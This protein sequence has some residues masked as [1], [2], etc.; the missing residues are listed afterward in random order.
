MRTALYPGTF[1][2][3]TN[4]HISLIRRG[5]QVFDRIIVAVADRTPKTP[6]FSQE[7]RVELMRRA[8]ADLKN[9]EVVPFTGLTVE[10]AVERG[11]S[12]ILRG[13]RAISDFEM[14]FQLALM[15]R[16]LNNAIETVFL[17]TDYRWLFISSTIVKNAVREGGTARGLV[18]DFVQRELEKAF[19]LRPAVE[20]GH[21]PLTWSGKNP[22]TGIK[23]RTAVYP[24]TFD[25]ITNGHLSVIRRALTT[26]DK[27]IVAVAENAGKKPLFSLAER[28]RF[29]EES[30]SDQAG[31]VEVAPYSN[32]TVDFAREHGA[33]AIVRGLR[34]TGDFEY[35]F[36]LALMNRR[37]NSAIQSVF[38][39]TDYQWLYVSSSIIKAAASHGGSINGLV[40]DRVRDRLMELYAGGRMHHSTPCLG[41]PLQGYPRQASESGD[42]DG[43]HA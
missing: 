19:G 21:R 29:V 18:P 6:L 28:V 35:E 14:E 13:M 7:Q 26:F 9:V 37:L 17:M 40:P 5:L 23:P 42:G 3:V 15:N 4:G 34:A 16:R 10:Y 33:C 36:Q 12:A 27:V 8:V 31:R 32:L 25:P 38:F 1:D 22:G 41:A 11:A 43:R 2:P 30:L 20:R 24:G 39:M